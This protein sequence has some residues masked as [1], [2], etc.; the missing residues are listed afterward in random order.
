MI[1]S[2]LALVVLLAGLWPVA[3]VKAQGLPPVPFP[4]GNPQTTAKALLGKALFWDEQLSSTR[5]VACGTCHIPGGGTA[6]PRTL[7]AGSLSM[8]PGLDASFGTP[9][10]VGGSFGV[11][12]NDAGGQYLP[13]A[14]GMSPQVTPRRTQ[15]VIMAAYSPTLFWDG[16]ASGEFRDPV[17]NAVLLPALAALESQALGPF[18]NEI[19]MGHAGRTLTDLLDRVNGVAPLA[20]ATNLPA[21]LDGFVNGRSYPDLFQA[22]FGTRD[23][24]PARIAMAL[25]TYQR[26][27]VPDQS[28]FDLGTM[29]GFARAGEQVFRLVGR[30]ALCHVPPLHP[31]VHRLSGSRRP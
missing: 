10:D 31:H 20:M 26:E 7:S 1:H 4:P 17:T 3:A 6:D 16:R 15:G 5:T 2:A 24:T 8:H 30:C 21:T 13:S 29:D 22:A 19:E 18:L 12:A 25:A 14:F 27:L 11:P 23:V 28:P 9:D